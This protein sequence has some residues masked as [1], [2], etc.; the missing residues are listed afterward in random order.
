MINGFLIT[1][2]VTIIQ[3]TERPLTDLAYTEA[4]SGSWEV[5]NKF[6]WLGAF[7]QFCISAFCLL[8]LAAIFFQRIVTMMYLSAKTMFDK[9]HEIK[10]ASY[11]TKFLGLG[12]LF[13]DS[14]IETKNGTGLDGIVS[15]LLSL[16]PD[17]HE[18]SDY[19]DG[20]RQYNLKDDDTVSAYMLKVAIP[21]ILS[22][23]FFAIGF[24]GTLF[25][26]Y[27]NVADAMA[28]AADYY[29][30]ADLSSTVMRWASSG[31]GY[32]FAYDKD[33][34]EIGKFKQRL[35]KDMY[36]KLLRKSSDLST[37]AKQYIGAGVANWIDENITITN[38]TSNV[39]GFDGSKENGGDCKNLNY[40]VV[41][42][43]SQ[44][45]NS[46]TNK[47][48]TYGKA[49]SVPVERFNIDKGT[50]MYLHVFISKKANANET[51]YFKV[52]ENEA[53]K[54]K[55]KGGSSGGS[56]GPTTEAPPDNK[57]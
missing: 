15:F 5:F 37:N 38:L 2:F 45:Y 27:C 33:G 44:N 31:S 13:K 8:G 10:K 50:G 14:I 43:S 40:S 4:F 54:N 7:M 1:S 28:T 51:N 19:H 20:A 52:D 35:A 48:I 53:T 29:V 24:N 21:T 49:G 57:K 56:N 22:V 39:A 25:K 47:S 16:M 36:A 3:M 55:N 42:N 18:Y 6:Q 34:T 17:V 32:Q 12:S 46:G 23:F 26:A 30:T 9:V 11:N 41:I